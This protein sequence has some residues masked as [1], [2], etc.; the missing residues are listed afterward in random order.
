M[1]RQ[2]RKHDRLLVEAAARLSEG[3]LRKVW[4]NPDDAQYDT[5][6]LVSSPLPTLYPGIACDKL[7]E[8]GARPGA[9][10][11]PAGT[12]PSAP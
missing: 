7:H 3:A 5:Y 1:S 9:G 11:R 6:S 10:L 8:R 12:H 2:C 4:D